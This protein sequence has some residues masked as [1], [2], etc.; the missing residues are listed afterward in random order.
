MECKYCKKYFNHR[1]IKQ[2]M[3]ETCLAIPEEYQEII[4]KNNFLKHK[5]N[6]LIKKMK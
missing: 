5:I 1:T 6:T 4:Q 3:K 2:H